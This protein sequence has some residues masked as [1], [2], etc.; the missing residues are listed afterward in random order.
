MAGRPGDDVLQQA[1]LRGTGT[2]AYLGRPCAG[3]TGTTSDYKDAWFCGYTPD[4]V[5]AVWVG[6][7]DRAAAPCSTRHQGRRRHLPGDDLE[8]FMGS[9]LSGVPTHV[10]PDYAAPPVKQAIVCARTGDLATR[11]CPERLKAYY[12]N[13]VLPD[14][15]LSFHKPERVAMPDLRGMPLDEA[16]RRCDASTSN[17]RSSGC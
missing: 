1:V 10:F 3:K 2:G 14:A 5:A 6:Y 7:V 15:D 16:S 13:G 17:G 4:L 9:A 11:W 12:F 8:K